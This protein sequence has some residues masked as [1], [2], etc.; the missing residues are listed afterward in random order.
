[1][2]ISPL[3]GRMVGSAGCFG[4]CHR[5]SRRGGAGEGGGQDIDKRGTAI[6][7]F[8]LQPFIAPRGS[9]DFN[10][11]VANYMNINASSP[12]QVPPLHE[13]VNT[14]SPPLVYPVR[15]ASLPPK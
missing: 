6:A 3:L 9:P 5:G 4:K 11:L 15:C 14:V 2:E 12:H 10:R 7:L 1:M 13:H 8:Y